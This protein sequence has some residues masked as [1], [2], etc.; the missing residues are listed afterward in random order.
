MVVDF[1]GKEGTVMYAK[2]LR[3][4]LPLIAVLA[5]ATVAAPTLIGRAS[6]GPRRD[7]RIRPAD[8]DA[9]FTTLF[10]S[11]LGLE[12]LTAD[13]QGNLYSAARGGDP[14][15]GWR[16]PASGGTAVVVGNVPAPCSPSGIAFNRGGRLFVA[17]GDEVLALRPSAQ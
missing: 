3:V 15:P 5:A 12:G 4:A 13:R 11:P 10:R 8:E 2:L 1:D 14:C 17:D 7:P 9:P 6:D 16:V